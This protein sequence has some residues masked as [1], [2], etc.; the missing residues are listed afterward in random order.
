M[1]HAPEVLLADRSLSQ[2][3]EAGEALASKAFCEAAR[4]LYAREDI[5]ALPVAGGWALHYG[6][7]DLLNAVKGVG[8]CDAVDFGAWNEMEAAFQACGSNVVVDCSPFALPEFIAGLHDR[9]YRIAGFETVLW[10]PVLPVRSSS[11]QPQPDSLAIECIDGEGA[12]AWTR[13]IG[14]G[15]ADGGEPM[16]F[17][18]DFGNVRASMG[19]ATMMFRATWDGVPAGAASLSVDGG[20]AHF[21]GAAVMPAFRRRGIQRALTQARLDAARAA[22]CELAKLDV[23][24]GSG[25][26]R[27]AERA[28]FRVAYSRPQWIRT[29]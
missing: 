15:F 25:S 4:R 29:W 14:S 1:T 21:G 23:L 13:L 7:G 10:Q 22:G 9:G 12:T 16:A 19:N 28:G 24:A 27:N 20:V 5:F 3:L 11:V 8:L 2:R 18:V 26:H 6:S 17:S